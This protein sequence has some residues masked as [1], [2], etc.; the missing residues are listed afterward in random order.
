MRRLLFK[1]LVHGPLTEAAPL[2]D[3]AALAELA[4]QVNRAA[5]WVER[6]PFAKSTRGPA[7]GASWRSTR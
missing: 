3:D 5:H 1:S 6:S 7:M 2:R 4:A